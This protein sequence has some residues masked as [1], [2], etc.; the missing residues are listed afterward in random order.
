MQATPDYSPLVRS[1]AYRIYERLPANVELDD[2]IQDGMVGMLTALGKDS[3]PGPQL[4]SYVGMVVK[5]AIYDSLRNSD[6]AP[7]NL[8]IESRPLG[9]VDIALGHKL[10]RKPTNGEMARELKMSMAEFDRL[11]QVR[12][13][14]MTPMAENEDGEA[15]EYPDQGADPSEQIERKQK[16]DYLLN[17]IR[18]LPDRDQQL[19]SMYYDDEMSF[20]EIGQVFGVTESQCSRLHTQIVKKLNEA[21]KG[22]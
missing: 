17:A 10:G 3:R 2:L 14:T 18:S 21:C 4:S 16:Q 19:L 7:R 11:R 13:Q 20:K 8:R 12:H 6:W 22:I 5:G 15:I 1:V 9:K